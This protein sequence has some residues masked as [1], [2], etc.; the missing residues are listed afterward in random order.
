MFVP[1]LP[2]T[3]R[4]F[5]VDI[6]DLPKI[7]TEQYVTNLINEFNNQKPIGYPPYNVIKHSDNKYTIEMALAGINESNIKVTVQSDLLTVSYVKPDE[8]TKNYVV[9]G[10]SQK[11][12]K[13]LFALPKHSDVSAKFEN[14]LLVLDVEVKLPESEQVKE[15]K[16]SKL[17]PQLLQE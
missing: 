16:I 10:I 11:S 6:G 7:K 4:V 1:Q 13:K 2:D 5:H 15:I 8:Q 3:R 14:G 12:F 9:R 17:Q